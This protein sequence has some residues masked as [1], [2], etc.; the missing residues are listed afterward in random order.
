[1]CVSWR[2][3]VRELNTTGLCKPPPTFY[4]GCCVHLQAG[5]AAAAAALV[6]QHSHVGRTCRAEMPAI[7]LYKFCKPFNQCPGQNSC[8]LSYGRI[9]NNWVE[10]FMYATSRNWLNVLANVLDAFLCLITR[11]RF[12]LE[13]KASATGPTRARGK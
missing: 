6:V 10:I 12:L 7:R 11:E 1:L 8:K 3:L 9:P 4:L 2:G 5:A 13:F